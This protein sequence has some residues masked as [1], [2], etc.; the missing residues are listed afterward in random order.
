MVLAFT[1]CHLADVYGL[2]DL[3]SEKSELE[4]VTYIC[5][6]SLVLVY[7]SFSDVISHLDVTTITFY[8]TSNQAM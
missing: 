8:S 3:K 2:A 7:A 6:A 1:C 5:R 4:P